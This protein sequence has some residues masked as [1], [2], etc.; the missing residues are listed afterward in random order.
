M[1]LGVAEASVVGLS[2]HSAAS[3][4]LTSLPD[5][6]ARKMP[7]SPDVPAIRLGRPGV[8]ISQQGQHLGSLPVL[9]ALRRASRNEL[10]WV[11]FRVGAKSERAAVCHERF[12]FQCFLEKALALWLLRK[13]AERLI[14]HFKFSEKYVLFEGNST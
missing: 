5:E 14:N 9:D 1:T 11:I 2:P 8:D 4:V 7:H 13:N 6:T 3:L 10:A 12:P